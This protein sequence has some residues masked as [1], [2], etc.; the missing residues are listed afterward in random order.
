MFDGV[1]LSAGRRFFMLSLGWHRFPQENASRP[2]GLPPNQGGKYVGFGST[3]PPRPKAQAGVDDLTQLF[4][5]TFTSV[6]KAAETAA[7][8]ASQVVKR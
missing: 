8:T 6:T 3:P 7:K 1:I 4:S 5:S 2:E